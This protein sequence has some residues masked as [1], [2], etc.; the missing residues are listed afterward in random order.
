[1]AKSPSLESVASYMRARNYS[2][3]T[4]QSHYYWIKC[5]ILFCGKQRP[6]RLGAAGLER[7]LTWLA[8]E[9]D[10]SPGTRSLALN[11]IVFV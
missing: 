6:E 3:R 10:V 11:A 4:I 5:F 7:F 9:R 8:V 2:K 1:M